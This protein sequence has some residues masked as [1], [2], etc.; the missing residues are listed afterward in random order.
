MGKSVRFVRLAASVRKLCSGR[1]KGLQRTWKNLAAD[2]ANLFYN[3]YNTS[4]MGSNGKCLLF[5][6][7]S[8]LGPDN[9]RDGRGNVEQSG[10]LVLML[11]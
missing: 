10:I 2:A 8:R 7:V 3:I 4:T 5:S 11:P 9:S 1:G 6:V